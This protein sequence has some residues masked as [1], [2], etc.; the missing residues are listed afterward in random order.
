M[1]RYSDSMQFYLRGPT[2]DKSRDHND[3]IKSAF[4]ANEQSG[5]SLSVN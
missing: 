3:Q 1:S 2:S 4:S 5:V